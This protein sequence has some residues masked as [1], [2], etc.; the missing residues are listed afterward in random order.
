MTNDYIIGIDL[1]T[2]NSAVTYIE[3]SLARDNSTPNIETFEIP[4]LTAPGEVSKLK[5]LPSFLY[6]PGEYELNK[7]G[8]EVA[9]VSDGKGF[10]G[11]F[12]RD[13]GTKVPKRMVSS[14][15]SWLC[16]GKVD[17]E[18]PILP[19]GADDQVERL[20]PIEATSAYLRHIKEAWNHAREGDE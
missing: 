15:K 19:W 18:A 11:A 12:A 2:T 9:W 8:L 13:Q 16:H 10:A 3:L 6:L 20:S 14:A 17:R 4:Q 1:G 7:D 5:V